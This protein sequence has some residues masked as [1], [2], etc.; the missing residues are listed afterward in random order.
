MVDSGDSELKIFESMYKTSDGEVNSL[1]DNK[2]EMEMM[3]RKAGENHPSS[4]DWEGTNR[5]SLT[6]SRFPIHQR[7]VQWTT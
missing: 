4:S 2:I 1:M 7:K 6:C 3:K 5:T